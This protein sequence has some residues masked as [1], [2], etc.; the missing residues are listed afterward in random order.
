MMKNVPLGRGMRFQIRA[1]IFNVFNTVN[2]GNP[3]A[4]F[5]SS[6]FGRINT[7]GPMRQMQLGGKLLF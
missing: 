7:A 6:A 1:E 2:Y 4:S 5:G 3:N